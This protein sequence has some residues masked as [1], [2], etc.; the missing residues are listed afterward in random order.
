MAVAAQLKCCCLLPTN[1]GDDGS[2]RVEL[3]PLRVKYPGFSFI[4]QE[5]GLGFRRKFQHKASLSLSNSSRTVD[6]AKGTS[7]RVLAET[8]APTVSP[9][10]TTGQ[11]RAF[12]VTG[13]KNVS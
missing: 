2:S 5:P 12:P 4:D 6:G 3:L 9:G 7:G 11:P 8:L 13:V 10:L 1:A